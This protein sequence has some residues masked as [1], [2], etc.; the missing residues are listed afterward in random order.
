MISDERLV[1]IESLVNANL[2]EAGVPAKVL[3]P[4]RQ[5]LPKGTDY[6]DRREELVPSMHAYMQSK[7][8]LPRQIKP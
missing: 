5:E 2:N 7:F 4:L 3:P 1:K 8:H 6:S